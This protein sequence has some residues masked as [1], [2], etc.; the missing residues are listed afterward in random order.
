M[1]VLDARDWKKEVCA[2][3]P[4]LFISY[5]KSPIPVLALKCIYTR[6]PGLAP[7]VRFRES[8]RGHRIFPE[9][10]H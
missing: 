8:I 7:V 6:L 10:K 1:V 3:S 4:S 2:S 5:K 9:A